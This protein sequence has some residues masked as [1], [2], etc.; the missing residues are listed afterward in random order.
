M[1][2]ILPFCL[3][4]L[5]MPLAAQDAYH[6]TL[7][8]QLQNDYALPA[9]TQWVLPNTESATF[10]AAFNYGSNVAN[11][12]PA[13]QIFTQA[14]QISVNQGNN[15]WDAGHLYQNNAAIV[16]GDKCLFVL[17][18]R[19]ATPGAKANIFVENSSTYEK[20]AFATVNIGAEWKMYAVPFASSASYAV[21]TL[22]LGLHLAFLNQVVDVGGI[23]CLNYKNTVVLNQLP[24]LLN[25]D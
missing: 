1:K 10:A 12:T 24:V 14:R 13:G 8:A 19:S 4:I 7:N 21:N 5:S 23:A 9:L 15:P 16:S 18:L 25:N 11:L 17:W 3:L 2:K 6:N 20:E 22:S